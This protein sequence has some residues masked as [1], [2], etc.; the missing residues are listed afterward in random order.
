M[1]VFTITVTAVDK[2]TAVV[3]GINKRLYTLAKP[4]IQVHQ[5]LS[6]LGNAL[7]LKKVG[8]DFKDFGLSAGK[9]TAAIGIAGGALF[10]MESRFSSLG[11]EVNRTALTLGVSAYNLQSLRGAAALAGVPVADLTGGLKS[12]GDTMEDALYGRNQQALMMLNR[13]GVGI[14]KTADGAID[15]VRGLKDLSAAIANI[16]SPQVQGLVARQFGLEA[17]LPLLRKGPAAIEEMQRKADA[18]G[19]V[20]DGPARAAAERYGQSLAELKLRFTGIKNSIGMDLMPVMEPLVQKFGQFV[21]T[22]KSLVAELAV[23]LPIVTLVGGVV[24]LGAA[25][26]TLALSPGGV[27]MLALIGGAAAIAGVV[28][29]FG[30]L[31]SMAKSAAGPAAGG[32]QAGQHWVPGSNRASGSWQSN[33]RTVGRSRAGGGHMEH[34]AGDHW[35]LGP[36]PGAAAMPAAP[37]GNAPLGIRYNNPLNMQPGGKE[38][39]YGS[40]DAG[41]DAGIGNLLRNYNGLTLSGIINKYAPAKGKGNSADTVSGYIADVSKQTGIGA[42]DAPNLQDPQV[43]GSLV[44]AMIRHEQGQN[45][46][47]AGVIDA[48]VN[49]AIQKTVRVE[50]AFANAPPGTRATIAQQDSGL[51]S[52]VRIGQ[53]MPA[54]P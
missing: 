24:A 40:V 49:R 54:M 47:S 43:L 21:T 37:S 32:Q 28:A 4:A 35:E 41:L 16:K 12:L 6:R 10:E 38:A 11:W 36:P 7:H 45:P 30:K 22:H 19:A 25:L 18:L 42:G 31:T 15:S 17:L 1:N 2:A 46:Y 3:N 14:H 8:K 34:W 20:M 5:S 52:A 39:Q 51:A 9:A 27:F 23:G 13:L 50:I 44:S 53:S 26:T 29:G 33:V 48:A